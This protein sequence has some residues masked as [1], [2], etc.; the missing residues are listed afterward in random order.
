MTKEQLLLEIGKLIYKYEDD[1]GEIVG[2]YIE[3]TTDDRTEV[4]QWNGDRFSQGKYTIK[5]EAVE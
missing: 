5:L 2:A 4:Y 3:P 1:T